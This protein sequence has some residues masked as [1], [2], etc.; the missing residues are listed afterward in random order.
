MKYLGVLFLFLGGCELF[1]TVRPSGKPVSEAYGGTHELRLLDVDSP[2]RAQKKVPI[3]STPEVFAVYVA[4]HAERDVMIGEHWLY[5]KLRDPE[6]LVERTQE[7]DPPTN[8]DAPAEHLR[9]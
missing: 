5:L 6:W 8:G 1:G 3:L 2:L 7:P 9:P 4:T